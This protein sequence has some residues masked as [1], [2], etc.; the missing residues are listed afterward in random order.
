MELVVDALEP[1]DPDA[2][3]ADPKDRYYDTNEK[4]CA[5]DDRGTQKP[6][7][8][9]RATTDNLGDLAVGLRAGAGQRWQGRS[10]LL[11]WICPP[12]IFRRKSSNC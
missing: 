7:G 8:R 11:A 2:I 1:G 10:A 4:S 6:D 12:S 5:R 3:T 9:R